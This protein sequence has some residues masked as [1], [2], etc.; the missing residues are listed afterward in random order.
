[1]G[2]L[3]NLFY[4]SFYSGI[5]AG[6][7]GVILPIYFNERFSSSLTLMGLVFSAYSILFILLQVP[8]SFLGDRFNRKLLLVLTPILSAIALL[9]YGAAN[10]V[11]HIFLGRGIDGLSNSLSRASSNTM[12]V[13]VSQ[14]HRLSESFGNMIGAF[15]LGYVLGFFIAGPAVNTVGYSRA[16]V[17]LCVFQAASLWLVLKI[18][19]G[20]AVKPI[21]FNIKKFFRRPHRNLKI[22]AATGLM[23]SLV[24]S[25]DYTVTVIYLK[26]VYSASLTQV[27]IVMGLGWLS[28]GAT[29]IVSGR[30]SDCVGRGRCYVYGISLACAAA[31]VIPKMSSIYGVALSLAVLCVGHGIAFPSVRGIIAEHTSESYRSQDFGFVSTFE[32]AGRFIGLPAMGL[33]ADKIGYSAAFYFRGAIL[34]TAAFTVYTLIPKKK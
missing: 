4:S 10:R 20:Q 2:N 5:A 12:L 18:R 15:S 11:L 9:T 27:G 17:S 21:K 31:L 22:L 16:L 19:Y 24:E 32:E 30:Y 6:A 13:E 28:F 29:Q 34:I 1:M 23:V 8:A 14:P 3:K 7:V 33:I 25:M 26:N